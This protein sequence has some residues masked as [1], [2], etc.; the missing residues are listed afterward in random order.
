MDLSNPIKTIVYYLLIGG[1]TCLSHYDKFPM[2]SVLVYV[3][4]TGQDL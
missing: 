2:V 1:M 3:I 4:H